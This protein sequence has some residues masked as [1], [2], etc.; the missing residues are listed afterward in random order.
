MMTATATVDGV[1]LG[2]PLSFTHVV[3]LGRD[4]YWPSAKLPDGSLVVDVRLFD[5]APA[6][7][8]RERLMFRPDALRECG[9]SEGVIASAAMSEPPGFAVILTKGAV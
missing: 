5:P 1:D 4:D 9:V 2:D 6:V 3:R 7:D 8:G